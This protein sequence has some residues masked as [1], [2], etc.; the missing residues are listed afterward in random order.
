MSELPERSD[1]V[2]VGAGFA[3]AA[4]ASAL[5]RRGV[6]DVVVLERETELGRYASGRSAGLGRQLAEDDDTTA[7]TV[8]GAQLLRERASWTHSGGL[9]SFDDVAHAEAYA[10]RAAR[11]EITAEVVDRD[12]VLA[13]WPYLDE[14]RIARALWI[15][16]D[17]TIDVAALLRELAAGARIV[18]GTG[19]TAVEP[20]PRVVTARGAIRARVVVDA[21]G[22]WAGETTGGPPLES[23]KRHV[24][25]LDA[26]AGDAVPWVW[27]LGRGELYVRADAG[28]VLMSPCDKSPC[29]PG[30]QQPDPVGDAQLAHALETSAP[31]LAR[32]PI[33]RRGA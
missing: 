20:G 16:S 21:A 8:H 30:D 10:A 17:G 1:V 3:G 6:T 27:H 22:A 13:R 15:P 12:G 4:T 25:L 2:I 9:L 33:T 28:R 14:V 26:A 7:L 5:A 18:L 24:F 29:A 19:V 11:F 31:E 23:F 32:A